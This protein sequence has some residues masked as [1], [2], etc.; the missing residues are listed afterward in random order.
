MDVFKRIIAC[1]TVPLQSTT[2][3]DIFYRW[4]FS[5]EGRNYLLSLSKDSER[6]SQLAEKFTHAKPTDSLW[7]YLILQCFPTESSIL[8]LPG[9]SYEDVEKKKEER[10]TCLRI[11]QELADAFDVAVK[12]PSGLRLKH[13]A[14]GNCHIN[15]SNLPL[16][17]TSSKVAVRILLILIELSQGIRGSLVV[18]DEQ[19]LTF[20]RKR[21]QCSDDDSMTSVLVIR[22]CGTL[23]GLTFEAQKDYRVHVIPIRSVMSASQ[24]WG[25]LRGLAAGFLDAVFNCLINSL[26]S[27]EVALEKLRATD[28]MLF[29]QKEDASDLTYAYECLLTE[30]CKVDKEEDLLVPIASYLRDHEHLRLARVKH[31]KAAEKLIRLEAEVM[32]QK[33]SLAHMLPGLCM[34]VVVCT[35]TASLAIYEIEPVYPAPVDLSFVP[36]GRADEESVDG[37][38]PRLSA[39][40]AVKEQLDKVPWDD[41]YRNLVAL[42]RAVYGSNYTR[43]L[44][45]LA[46][47]LFVSYQERLSVDESMSQQEAEVTSLKEGDKV[48]SE[49]GARSTAALLYYV[50]LLMI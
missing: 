50:E 2:S 37:Q 28:E 24:G 25:H 15:V 42:E 23:L 13:T 49:R 1:D 29:Q 14:F 21:L 26:A 48:V 10:L 5:N 17:E 9:E 6:L 7:L 19:I 4:S 34:I 39:K 45:C 31:Q 11:F 40:Q 30:I 47:R 35:Y 36:E 8:K 27:Y 3:I 12:V 22:T 16:I 33:E 18:Q 46:C 20:L 38:K 44:A 41:A 32:A 43:L